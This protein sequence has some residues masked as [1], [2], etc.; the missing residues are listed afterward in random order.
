MSISPPEVRQAPPS[1]DE[2]RSTDSCLVERAEGLGRAAVMEEVLGPHLDAMLRPIYEAGISA[3]NKGL[4]SLEG[5]FPLRILEHC[6]IMLHPPQSFSCLG[7]R[8]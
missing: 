5:E 1:E 3:R 2:V 4:P 8:R 6:A 7:Q